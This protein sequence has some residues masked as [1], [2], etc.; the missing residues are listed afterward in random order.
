MLLSKLSWIKTYAESVRYFLLTAAFIVLVNLLDDAASSFPSSWM[1][2]L[3]TSANEVSL[4]V[5]LLCEIIFVAKRNECYC[6][7]SNV[8]V[9]VT[10]FI[11]LSLEKAVSVSRY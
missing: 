3:S 10:T 7:Y 8:T 2:V 6:R 1:I 4:F 9:P 5:L 11:S